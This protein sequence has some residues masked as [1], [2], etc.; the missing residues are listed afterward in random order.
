VHAPMAGAGYFDLLT[1]VFLPIKTTPS[2]RRECRSRASAGTDI[3]DADDKIEEKSSRRP[4]KLIEV[5]ALFSDLLPPY[6]LNLK[7]GFLRTEYGFGVGNYCR[8]GEKL[9]LAL[10]MRRWRGGRILF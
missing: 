9:L 6:L 8:E 5:A 10:S 4:L 7:A 1:M 2:P 3:V